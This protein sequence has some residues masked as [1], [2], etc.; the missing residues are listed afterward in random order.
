MIVKDGGASLSRCLASVRGVVDE[1]VVVDTGSHDDSV[2]RAQAAGARVLHHAWSDDFAAARNVGLEAA[3]GDW[4]LLL[5]SDERFE[6][7]VPVQL[8]DA[9]ERPQYLGYFLPI[10]SELARGEQLESTILRLWRHSPAARFRFP[11]H[12]QVLPDLE[13]IAAKTGQR[14]ALLADLKVVHDGYT[15]DAIA[16]HGKVARNLRLF[17]KAVAERPDEPY[18]WY[19]FADF[20]RGQ[21]EH[22]AEALTAAERALDLLR[23]RAESDDRPKAAYWSELLTILCASRLEAGRR[24]EALALIEQEPPVDLGSPHYEYVAALALEGEGRVDEALAHLER[25]CGA[26][27]P[28]HLT[29]WRPSI[30]GA[31]GHALRARLLARKGDFEGSVAAARRSQELQPGWIA[32]V[33]LEADALLAAGRAGDA[34]KRL[35]EEVRKNP[36][37]R[38]WQQ[39]GALLLRLG[40]TAE[41][42]RCLARAEAPAAT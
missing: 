2:A 6:P 21:A 1:I 17:R 31:Q 32:A 8:R 36:V 19:K 35:L 11:I 29:A 9:L 38:L 34:L 41:A 33:Q 4:I 25:C 26:Q 27:R 13:A 40:R 37:P 14:F 42:Q 7:P 18:L 24:V 15:P 23:A 28:T 5:D 30:A 22:K 10:R 12:E 39:I 20:L 3:S 16:T